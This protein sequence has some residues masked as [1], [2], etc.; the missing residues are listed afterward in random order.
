MI[1][2]KKKKNKIREMLKAQIK[3]S[4]DEGR[5]LLLQVAT[6]VGVAGEDRRGGHAPSTLGPPL[7]GFVRAAMR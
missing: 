6:A 1:S 2:K 7:Q 4:K 5:K 3:R